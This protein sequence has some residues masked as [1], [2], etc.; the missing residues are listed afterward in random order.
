MDVK[1]FL[2]LRGQMAWKEERAEESY[3]H[4]QESW[5][6]QTELFLEAQGDHAGAASISHLMSAA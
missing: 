1:L 6:G 3:Y 5:L 2:M 4:G